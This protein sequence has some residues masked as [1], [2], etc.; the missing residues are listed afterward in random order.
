MDDY[1][2]TFYPYCGAVIE[3]SDVGDDLN[4]V[5]PECG[6]EFDVDDVEIKRVS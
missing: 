3:L 5:C 6:S 2:D 1:L 4:V